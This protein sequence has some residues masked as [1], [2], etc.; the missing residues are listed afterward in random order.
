MTPE[1][2]RSLSAPRQIW[3]R[4]GAEPPA[5]AGHGKACKA[6]RHVGFGGAAEPVDDGLHAAW[7]ARL[8]R[9]GKLGESTGADLPAGR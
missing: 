8:E 7:R 1:R 2:E 6:M 4:S 5:P 3:S 9:E